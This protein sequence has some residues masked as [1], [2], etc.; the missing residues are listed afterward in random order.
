MHYRFLLTLGLM[1]AHFTSGIAQESGE[2]NE[3]VRFT[4]WG[5]W[6]GKDLFVKVPGAEAKPDDGFLKLDLLDLGYSAAIPFRRS[7]PIQ[8]CTRL[9][10]DGETLWQPLLTITIPDGIRE[11][12]VMIF[13]NGEGAARH[14]IFD[15]HA[16]EFPY[17]DYQLV[18]LTELRLFAKLDETGILLGPG[19]TGHFKGTG[20]ASLNVWLRVAAEG[21]D[22]NAHVV[23]S[24]MMRNRSDKRMFM[25][26]HSNDDSRGVPIAVRTLVDFAPQTPEP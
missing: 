9:D 24:S 26:F 8:L 19:A 16:S 10:Q 2:K 13:P 7:A 3:T 20:E 11:P 12:L 15:L 23:Y 22:K 5:D 4:V 6:A 21:V 14:R 17:G 18:N 1:L 25:F